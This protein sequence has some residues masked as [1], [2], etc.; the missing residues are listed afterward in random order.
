MTPISRLWLFVVVLIVYCIFL[1]NVAEAKTF[2]NF[3]VLDVDQ[4]MLENDRIV[5]HDDPYYPYQDPKNA[6]KEYWQQETAV[7]FDVDVLAYKHWSLYWRNRVAGL[8]TNERYRETYWQWEGGFDF[9]KYAQVYWNHRSE[10]LLD[11]SSQYHFPLYNEYG[12]RVIL[13]NRDRD[14]NHK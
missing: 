9:N 6:T 1:G 11:A 12:I 8:S 2:G 5:N 3:H 7:G 13:Y 10:H 4:F 14:W